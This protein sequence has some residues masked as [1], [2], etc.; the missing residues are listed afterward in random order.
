MHRVAGII[1]ANAIKNILFHGR[2]LLSNP[3]PRNFHID[4][5]KPERMEATFAGR[6]TASPEA[7]GVI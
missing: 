2:A 3:P 4:S 7:S 1:D 6:K 5:T